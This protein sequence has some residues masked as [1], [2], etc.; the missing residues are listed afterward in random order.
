[1]IYL[2]DKVVVLR[3]FTE[4]SQ[5]NINIREAFVYVYILIVFFFFK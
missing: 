5:F 2:K 1:M 4:K 3:T